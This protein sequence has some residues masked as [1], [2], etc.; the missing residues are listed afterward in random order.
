MPSAPSTL[1][2]TRRP[3]VTSPLAFRQKPQQPAARTNG[4]KKPP[5][6]IRT[7]GYHIVSM[8]HGNDGHRDKKR[9]GEK[10]MSS[11]TARGIEKAR[12]SHPQQSTKPRPCL[13]S[14]R[15]KQRRKQQQ[16]QRQSPN[17]KKLPGIA[18]PIARSAGTLVSHTLSR[19]AHRFQ[20]RFFA[21]DESR[22]PRCCHL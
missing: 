22:L 18:H 7:Q 11:A 6:S 20:L 17:K 5:P 21:A 8:Q 10:T 16:Q 2:R 3:R 1:F 13:D 12:C 15:G 19:F 14:R 9:S 4:E